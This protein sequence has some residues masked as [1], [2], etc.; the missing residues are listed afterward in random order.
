MNEDFL[1]TD[2]LIKLIEMTASKKGILEKIEEK[3]RKGQTEYNHGKE[4]F[5]MMR[6]LDALEMAKKHEL[7][8][9]AA[10]ILIDISI[11][12]ATWGNGSKVMEACKQ[13]LKYAKEP[14]TKAKLMMNLS[15]QQALD[16]KLEKARKTIQS[17]SKLGTSQAIKGKIKRNLKIINNAID[18]RDGR[19][20]KK[21]PKKQQKLLVVIG[22]GN[23]KRRKR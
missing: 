20:H 2:F 10:E 16:Y 5:A 14:N 19:I 1:Y 6:N 21:S 4:E 9:K 8:E 13:G 7:N 12:H 17:A 11:I 18:L 3:R 15:N 22:L 23:K